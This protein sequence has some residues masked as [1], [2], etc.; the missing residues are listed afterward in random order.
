MILRWHFRERMEPRPPLVRC[1]GRLCQRISSR[2]P[3]AQ[4]PARSDFDCPYRLELAI[5]PAPNGEMGGN[6]RVSVRTLSVE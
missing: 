4:N 5:V 1:V 2:A 3:F 6:L